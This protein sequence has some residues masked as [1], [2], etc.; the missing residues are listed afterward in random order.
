M[1]AYA[2]SPRLFELFYPW[3]LLYSPAITTGLRAVKVDVDLS[4]IPSGAS[5]SRHLQPSFATLRRTTHGI[6][7]TTRGTIPL[8]GFMGSCVMSFVCGMAGGNV[9]PAPSVTG[10]TQVLVPP[11][12]DG[13]AVKPERVEPET[14]KPDSVKPDSIDTSIAP[15]AGYM[16]GAGVYGGSSMPAYGE[17]SDGTLAPAWVPT[18]A[19]PPVAKR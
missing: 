8:P 7:F 11:V 10:R 3:V 19:V 15:R 2:D 18:K 17:A 6:E 9:L 16:R 12:E 13:N 14:V 5:I 1:I 4:M